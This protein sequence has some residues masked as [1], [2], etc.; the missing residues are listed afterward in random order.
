M[1]K[2]EKEETNVKEETDSLKLSKLLIREFN[3]SSDE[4]V[5]WCLATDLDNPTT[6][7][8]FISTGSTLLDYLIANRRNGGV[9]VGKLT[10]IVGEEASG[11]SLIAAH[12]IAECQRRD[13]I[14]IYIDTE[15]AA[16]S[17]FMRQVGVNIEQMVY[18][19]PGTVEEVGED[20]E[21]T[22]L[23]VRTKAPNKLVLIVWDSIAGTPPQAEI[24]G[25]Y[26]AQSHMGLLGKAMALMMR[27]L[28]QTLGKE[29]IAL[30]F[31]NQ[32]KYRIGVSYGDPM[33]APG[34]KAVPFHAST[35]IRLTRSVQLKEGKKRGEETGEDV[36][37]AVYGIHTLAK[38][39]KSR[40][41]PP[42][43]KC[44]FDITFAF[45][46]DDETS[47]F[48]YLHSVGEIEKADGWCYYSSYPSG[49]TVKK[50]DKD[51][52]KKEIEYD[53]GLQF[54]EKQWREKLKED[55]KFREKILD[56]L[57]KHLV[58]KYGETP[59]D[60]DLDPESLLDNE[61]VV[62]AVANGQL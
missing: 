57:E 31:T 62:E 28:T 16:N 56:D 54:R 12:L 55:Q 41:G 49:K 18:L 9:A 47:W 25:N 60:I 15:N 61:A 38:V 1:S 37:G 40:L 19:Q 24:E 20:I 11:K 2:K 30:V 36:K 7:K 5:A 34:G 44:E 22:I 46:I 50:K 51:N 27:K 32:L 35:R 58:I 45:G 21:K 53:R 43:R 10:E 26:D 14:A 8:E 4:K 52:P 3:N 23:K 59:K 29:R 42:L 6:V 33:F 39:I 13:G 17:D 48:D